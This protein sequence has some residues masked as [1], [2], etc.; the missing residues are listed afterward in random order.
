MTHHVRMT[1]AVFGLYLAVSGCAEDLY[2]Y[3]MRRASV[4]PWTQLSPADWSEI[5]RL[6]TA[7]TEQGIQG[8]TKSP[9]NSKQISVFTGFSGAGAGVGERFRW[10]EFL[11]EKRA[12]RWQIVSQ[13]CI[14][15]FLAQLSLSH[16]PE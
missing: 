12:S 2:A 3:N 6:V 13:D 15:P 4:T 10:H 14:S 11:L 7:A 8:I 9:S 16:P 1:V 5:V